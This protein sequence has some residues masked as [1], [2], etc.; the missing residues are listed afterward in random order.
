MYTRTHT[1]THQPTKDH[2]GPVTV[3][4]VPVDYA[5]GN[6]PRPRTKA[7]KSQCPSSV[8]SY[9]KVTIF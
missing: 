7:P 5:L 6:E 9:I 1:H 2:V 8:F 3:E 4:A